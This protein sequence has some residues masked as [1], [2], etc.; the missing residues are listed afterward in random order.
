MKTPP[1]LQIDAGR[2]LDARQRTERFVVWNL[3]DHLAGEGW[4]VKHVSD[5][6]ERYKTASQ[7]EVMELVFN[8]DESWLYAFNG[9]R[10]HSIFLVLGNDGYDAVA[11]WGYSDGDADG[12][13][14]LMERFDGE[15]YV[16]S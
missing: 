4:E 16:Q 10:R 9:N 11:D 14:A 12:F 8:L 3:L 6:A 15:D 1:T 13:N 2:V 7:Q 5:G